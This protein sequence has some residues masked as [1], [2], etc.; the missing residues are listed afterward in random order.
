M[1]LVMAILAHSALPAS[2][3]PKID[4][5]EK[6]FNFGEMVEGQTVEHVYRVQNRGDQ[7]LEIQ[8]L[9]ST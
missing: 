2:A 3:A 5:K 1:L 9:K 8:Q 7:P 4:V 6:V